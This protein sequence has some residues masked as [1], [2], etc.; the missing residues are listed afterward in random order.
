MGPDLGKLDTANVDN[1]HGTREN[2]H[3]ACKMDTPALLK[4]TRHP[5]NMDSAPR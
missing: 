2:G 4:W 5:V 3:G 1:G